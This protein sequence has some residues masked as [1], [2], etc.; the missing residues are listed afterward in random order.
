M[1]HTFLFQELPARERDASGMCP[2]TLALSERTQG[3]VKSEVGGGRC[4]HLSASHQGGLSCVEQGTE[5]GQLGQ[6][7]KDTHTQKV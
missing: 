4:L 2:V 7:R 1:Q 3:S 5:S 6:D